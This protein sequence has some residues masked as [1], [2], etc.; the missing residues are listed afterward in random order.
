MT[1]N[2]EGD[3]VSKSREQNPM[4]LRG[5]PYDDDANDR[6][7]F[8]SIPALAKSLRALGETFSILE[9]RSQ[10]ENRPLTTDQRRKI[11]DQ[12]ILILGE[13]YV[14]RDLK[15]TRHAVDPVTAL[16]QL[17]RRCEDLTGFDFHLEVMKVFK[18]LRDIHTA[19]IMPK[20]YS[21]MVAFLPF[22]L[23]A[24]T[25]RETAA[26]QGQVR[27]EEK[28]GEDTFDPDG[29][30]RV[31]V[32][33][34]LDKFKHKH[35]KPGVE[36]LSWNGMPIH[37]AIRRI[38]EEEQGSNIYAQFE[39][40]LRLMTVRWLGGSL[41]PSEYFVTVVYRDKKKIR[42]IRF[43]WRVMLDSASKGRVA[44][45]Q[46]MWAL[47]K[48]FDNNTSEDPSVE[49]R[50]LF[51]TT[52]RD[53]LFSVSEKIEF[54]QKVT[55]FRPEIEGLPPGV[56][57]VH[58]V[59]VD[60]GPDA[61]KFGLVKIE[62]FVCGRKA[63][64]E[65]FIKI[66][67][68]VPQTG[69]VIDIRSNPG[70]L[71]SAAESIL[72]LLSPRRIT[73][74]PFQF[75]ATTLA[76]DIVR[77]DKTAAKMKLNSWAA[78]VTPAVNIGNQFS[79]N[80][81]LTRKDLANELGQRYYGP[82]TLITNAVTYSSGDIF[83]ASFQD[84][85]IGPVIGTDPSTGGGG[86]NMWTHRDCVDMAMPDQ[87]LEHLPGGARHGPKLHYA[88]RRC[89]RVGRNQG[90]PIEEEGVRRDR[91]YN[92]TRDDLL[93]GDV[94]LLRFA[95]SVL[96]EKTKEQF[97][98]EIKIDK[99]TV[100]LSDSVIKVPAKGKTAHV[101]INID[102]GQSN[103]KIEHI[104]SIGGKF[105][106]AVNIEDGRASFSLELDTSKPSV[107]RVET[108]DV[109]PNSGYSKTLFATFVREVQFETQSQ[110]GI[111]MS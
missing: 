23:A 81:S 76:E 53:Q 41:P 105:Q 32:T 99:E 110:S 45:V 86:A 63:F 43:P 52:V 100:S 9:A 14:H 12:A 94:D 73:P 16:R 26:P 2:E 78:K 83:A 51:E 82:V 15:R 29:E 10:S 27:G 49:P 38:G 50:S 37:E 36:I 5:S 48:K 96:Q 57:D 13:L 93:S 22:L 75:L 60:H 19:Y 6:R 34:M 44:S 64:V 89:V 61:F 90:M 91:V 77:S 25:I 109:D 80:G 67:H 87:L 31:I 111:N 8:V 108:H 106:K 102:L 92:L 3:T 20:P 95:G 21:E 88:V 62:N 107:V 66:L 79:R 30:R 84:H 33:G 11:L 58:Y 69:L 42:E 85:E 59:K 65:G 103:S 54:S 17:K 56:F 28:L 104:I 97:K 74:L 72:Q 4:V 24:H 68:S 101:T 7:V 35:F 55:K 1:T 71:V 18:G 70:G 98:I 40:G 47:K 39:L 46:A